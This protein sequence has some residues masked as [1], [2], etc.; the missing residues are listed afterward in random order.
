[1]M[2]ILNSIYFLF[3]A[4]CLII[5]TNYPVSAV[6]QVDSS[7]CTILN[8]QDDVQDPI[9]GTFRR[10]LVSGFNRRVNRACTNYIS[11]QSGVETLV[12]ARDTF[13]IDGEGDF[14]HDA[15]RSNLIIQ[16]ENQ[17]IVFDALAMP[18]GKCLFN[19]QPDDLKVE[20]RNAIIKIHY[21][22]DL[23]CAPR[24]YATGGVTL[25]N[26]VILS[27]DPPPQT[28]YRENSFGGATQQIRPRAGYSGDAIGAVENVLSTYPSPA[29]NI[30]PSEPSS[31]ISPV[32]NPL[33]DKWRTPTLKGCTKRDIEGNC[34]N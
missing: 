20:I 25:T 4:L 19:I 21:R 29:G 31:Q 24:P 6:A 34:V 26:V 22:A 30:G 2:R 12:E 18:P 7:R 11:G 13:D 3:F 8:S 17:N 14:D 15:N 10:A 5:G 23:F 1:M 32:Q 33:G 16:G 28:P 9:F 27:E